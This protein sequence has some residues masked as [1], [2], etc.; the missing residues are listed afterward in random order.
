MVQSRI[1]KET[2]SFVIFK[3]GGGVRTPSPRPDP[4]M[5]HMFSHTIPTYMYVSCN[6]DSKYRTII[7]ILIR[8]VYS[9]TCVNRPLSKR[10]KIGFHD[11]LSLNVGQKYCRMLQ[12]EHS[13]ILSTFI[14]L[15]YVI[16]E[17][18]SAT[19]NI[20]RFFLFSL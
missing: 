16:K 1:P 3:G 8:F 19:M 2:Y 4:R 14:K 7:G 18:K 15:P 13:A 6:C 20:F 10:P 9:K 12:W 11:Q 5:L 17:A